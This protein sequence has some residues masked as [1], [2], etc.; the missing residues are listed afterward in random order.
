MQQRIIELAAQAPCSVEYLADV[1]QQPKEAIAAELKKLERQGRLKAKTLVLYRAEARATA[2]EKQLAH[3]PPFKPHR[4]S[5]RNRSMSTL[6][7]ITAQISNQANLSQSTLNRKIAKAYMVAEWMAD[8]EEAAR[9]L[10]RPCLPV[11]S[12]TPMLKISATG[13]I[14]LDDVEHLIKPML[15]KRQLS[16]TRGTADNKK[17]CIR[18]T[19]YSASYH[20]YQPVLDIVL[21]HDTPIDRIGE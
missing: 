15:E 9:A 5:E 19:E 14:T 4:R 3:K 8:I 20:T 1:L 18:L 16:A 10:E 21:M 11:L 7:K 6:A 17:Q 13:G 2:T 12:D